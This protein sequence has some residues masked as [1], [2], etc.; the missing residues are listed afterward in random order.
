MENLLKPSKFEPNNSNNISDDWIYW[1]K[2][3]ENFLS[4]LPEANNTPEKH[5]LLLTSCLSPAVYKIISQCRTYK[6]AIDKLEITYVK[7]KNEI[8][9]R[10][11][12]STRKQNTNESIDSFVL[13]LEELAKEC[14][15][16]AV[17]AE[18]NRDENIRDS[19]ITGL[20]SAIIRERLLENAT[21]TLQ[22]AVNQ[23]RSLE[24]AHNNAT[25]YYN[26]AP[27]QPIG[28]I[29]DINKNLETC[30]AAINKP[31]AK[32]LIVISAE[33]DNMSVPNVQ[34]GS[35]RVINVGKRDISQKFA[36]VTLMALPP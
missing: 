31:Y 16:Q 19:F 5:L 11:L 25:Q 29:D 28:A 9:A 30:A 23:A 6:E 22:E 15:Y 8:F 2:C 20:S 34:L 7:P 17:P 3:F 36:V 21:L 27:F 4:V 13:S 33:G 10:F 12:L 26:P 24:Q 35:V 1:R 32:N 18:V 14:N